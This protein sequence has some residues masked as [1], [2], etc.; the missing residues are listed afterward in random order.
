MSL[1][2]RQYQL[3]EKAR[4]RR[5]VTRPL[6]VGLILSCTEL[7]GLRRSLLARLHL[8]VPYFLED[9][10]TLMSYIKTYFLSKSKQTSWMT[11]TMAVKGPC[12]FVPPQDTKSFFTFLVFSRSIATKRQQRSYFV[13]N[14]LPNCKF[15]NISVMF[16]A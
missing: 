7:P 2:S 10:N 3:Q 4:T 1:S 9:P 14:V 6:G 12:K 5:S 16:V 15:S 13:V 11:E 8:Q